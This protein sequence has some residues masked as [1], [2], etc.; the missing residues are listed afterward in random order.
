MKPMQVTVS[1]LQ[2]VR[3]FKNFVG[4]SLVIFWTLSDHQIKFL[5]ICPKSHHKQDFEP[6]LVAIAD[7]HLKRFPCKLLDQICVIGRLF[8]TRMQ[9]TR[10]KLK[11]QVHCRV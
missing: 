4:I 11:D 8:L 1:E 5:N 6:C 2:K 7:W 3:E 9:K 10:T